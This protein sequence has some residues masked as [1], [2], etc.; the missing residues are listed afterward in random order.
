[1]LAAPRAE[2]GTEYHL[3]IANTSAVEVGGDIRYMIQFKIT[4]DD[5]DERVELF[6][7]LIEGDM[8]DEDN[9]TVVFN[10]TLAQIKGQTNSGV[11]GD[12]VKENLV[13]RWKGFLQHG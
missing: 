5:P 1:M 10:K 8:D 12:D 6:K 7:D 4:A 11:W 13:Q 9:I 2:I 3:D